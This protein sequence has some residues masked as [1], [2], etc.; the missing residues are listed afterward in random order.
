[1]SEIHLNNIGTIF[2]FTIND[3]NGVYD[4]SSLVT[5]QLIFQKPNSLTNL[6]KNAVFYTDGTDGIIQYETVSGDLNVVGV[7]KVQAYLV[8]SDGNEYYSN[9]QHFNVERNL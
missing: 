1:M 6:V 9:I 5:K 4:C 3:S 8:D 7:W 2:R